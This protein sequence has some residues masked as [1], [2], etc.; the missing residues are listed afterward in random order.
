MGSYHLP[1][2]VDGLIDGLSGHRIA[3]GRGSRSGVP[4]T[5]RNRFFL[6]TPLQGVD[7]QGPERHFSPGPDLLG[8]LE[9]VVRHIDGSAHE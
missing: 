6:K 5:E 2:A 7:H 8:F 3:R 9:K 4:K 1:L